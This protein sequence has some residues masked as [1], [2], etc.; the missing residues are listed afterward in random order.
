MAGNPQA[1][2]PQAVERAYPV[3]ASRLD[4]A[5]QQEGTE[6]FHLEG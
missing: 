1:G 3:V 6:A 5:C 2:N 4:L